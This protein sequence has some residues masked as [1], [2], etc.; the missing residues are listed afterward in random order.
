MMSI[1]D[2]DYHRAKK[3]PETYLS[4]SYPVTSQ[5]HKLP[6]KIEM[7]PKKALYPASTL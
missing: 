7:I 5:D 3:L 2:Q 6:R 1:A 4:G